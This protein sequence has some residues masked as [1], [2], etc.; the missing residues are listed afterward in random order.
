M[1]DDWWRGAAIYQI[2]PLSFFDSNGDGFGDLPGI[3]AKL[4]YIASL[5]VD[6]IWISPFF[7]SPMKD[8]GY[9]V[10]DYCGVDPTFGTLR[11][12]QRLARKAK[13][14]GL[15]VII[16]Q[17]WSH[18][19]DAHPWFVQSRQARSGPRADW[20]IWHDPSPDGTP[21]NNWLAV[22]GGSAWTWE[23]RRRQYYLH[24]FLDTQPALNLRNDSVIESLFDGARFWIEQGVDGFRFDAVDFM[25]HDEALR[26]NPAEPPEGGRIPSK[27]FGLQAHIYDMAHVDTPSLLERIRRFLSAYPDLVSLGEVSSQEGALARIGRYTGLQGRRL[28]MAYTLETMKQGFSLDLFRN[29]IAD[30]EEELGGGWLCWAF[31]NHDVDRVVSRWLQP[32]MTDPEIRPKFARLLMALLLTMR[33][34]VCIYQGEELG[35]PN[36]EIPRE[37]MRDPY[38]IAF[39]PAFRGRDASRT[40][41]PWTTDRPTAGFTTSNNPWLPVP[42]VHR[43]LAVSVET[44]DPNS[45]LTAW[46]DFLA[47]RRKSQA[48][49][50][51]SIQLVDTAPPILAFWRAAEKQ[52]L[53]VLLNFA[54]EAARYVAPTPLA[55]VEGIRCP[56]RVNGNDCRLEPFGYLVATT[57]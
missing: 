47:F 20:Y 28:H 26:S 11:D 53:L 56:A 16:D 15:K 46:R 52:R 44:D 2:Y 21:P 25:L 18:T 48:L 42:D 38:G 27:P 24:H 14:L 3:A 41:M 50:R 29:A 30:A 7:P 32:G 36:V 57:A 39:Y 12:F 34:S 45:V 35:L 51:G 49:R 8:F 31:S 22:F 43:R 40:P 33:G 55:P 1:S 23:P 13:D 37:L 5:G 17:V 10:S 9:D 19:S 4:D 6:A 54:N